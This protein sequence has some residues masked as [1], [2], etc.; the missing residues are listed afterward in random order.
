MALRHFLYRDLDLIRDFLAEL[1]GGIFEAEVTRQRRGQAQE[2]Q[3]T[4]DPLSV[5]HSEEKQRV[6]RQTGAS[7]FAR[8]YDLLQD[9][10]DIRLLDYAD[11]KVWDKLRR[12]EILEV[13]ASL[14]AAG[15]SQYLELFKTLQG[16]APLMEMGGEDQAAGI[17][18]LAD[19][20]KALAAGAGER[21]SFVAAIASAPQYRFVTELRADSMLVDV[22][23]FAG[24]AT[25]VGKVQRKLRPGE[26]QL[27]GSFLGGMEK[28]LPPEELEKFLSA[29][30]SPEMKAIGISPPAIEAPAAVLTPIA[31]FR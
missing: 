23:D 14:G 25:I 1:E 11:D 16:F 18:D 2:D 13:D 9:S 5:S 4:G 21:V 17:S 30:D 28:M 24:E 12:G 15:V 31:V 22:G 8:L 7:E 3:A 29:F 19:A 26:R 10:D 20:A 27:V 6:L